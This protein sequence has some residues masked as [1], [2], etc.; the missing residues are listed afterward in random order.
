MKRV[1]K[2]C[3]V[4]R[5]RLQVFKVYITEVTTG[6]TVYRREGTADGFQAE[7]RIPKKIT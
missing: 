1:S 2:D 7:T 3:Y 4:I 6:R 5:G